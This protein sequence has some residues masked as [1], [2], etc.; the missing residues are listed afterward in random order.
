MLFCESMREYTMK[1]SNI[2]K[3]K[4]LLINEQKKTYEKAKIYYISKQ[5]IEY[6]YTNDKNYR[7][8]I[9]SAHK[10]FNL[11][12]SIPNKIPVVSHNQLNYDYYFIIKKKTSKR[13]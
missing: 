12:Y 8:V 3:K 9:F 2:E 1:I 10:K 11:K 4:I 7:K 6:K 5:K 13:A